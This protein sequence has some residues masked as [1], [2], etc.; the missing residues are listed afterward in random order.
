VGNEREACYHAEVAAPAAP[1]GPEQVRVL[2]LARGQRLA[3][4]GDDLQGLQVVASQAV[5]P[6]R[7]AHA[8]AK[9]QAGQADGRAGPAWYRPALGREAV[10]EVD[11]PD[12]GPE[13]R[14][15]PG[16]R[17]RLQVRHV[18][19]QPAGRRPAGVAV[20]AAA[21]RELELELAHERQAG[22]HVVRALDVGDARRAQVVEPGI[23]QQP[24]GVVAGVAGADQGPGQVL[25][26]RAPV[27]R[28]RP[29]GGVRDLRHRAC[30]NGGGHGRPAD[31]E[32]AAAAE[33]SPRFVRHIGKDASKIATVAPIFV[34]SRLVF[35]EVCVE[36]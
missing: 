32:E 7:H 26:Q 14:R 1:A 29:G 21:R 36:R 13:R 22:G 35:R 18:D 12:A 23:E 24:G 31:G 11:E 25:G 33:V 3:V 5:S 19:D 34:K 27:G 15:R 8:A 17:H 6:G 20:P 30:Y 9:G 28:G 16:H 4:S 2:G 10:V